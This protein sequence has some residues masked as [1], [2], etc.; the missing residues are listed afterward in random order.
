MKIQTYMILDSFHDF[1]LLA[2]QSSSSFNFEDK[3]KYT[4]LPPSHPTRGIF[5]NL[6]HEKIKPIQFYVIWHNTIGR[7]AQKYVHK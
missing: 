5:A 3:S 1:E 7:I 6:V 2:E 4:Q